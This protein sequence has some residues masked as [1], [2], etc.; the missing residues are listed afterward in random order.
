M[1]FVKDKANQLSETVQGK[2]SEAQAKSDKGKLTFI[3]IF[4]EDDF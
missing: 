2:G 3:A 4:V 1:D